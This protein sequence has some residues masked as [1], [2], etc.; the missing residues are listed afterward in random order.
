[1]NRNLAPLI[2][3]VFG[4]R[5]RAVLGGSKENS[6]RDSVNIFSEDFWKIFR[7]K[8]DGIWKRTEHLAS[9]FAPR[10]PVSREP[11]QRRDAEHAAHDFAFKTFL[12]IR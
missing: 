3:H 12:T 6:F 1:M 7:E 5:R 4:F 2:R 10:S 8:P 9:S 11:M